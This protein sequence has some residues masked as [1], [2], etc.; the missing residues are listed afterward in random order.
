[1]LNKSIGFQVLF[2]FFSLFFLAPYLYG[3]LNDWS[4][5]QD[6]RRPLEIEF[7]ML[8]QLIIWLFIFFLFFLFEKIKIFNLFYLPFIHIIYEKFFSR[9]LAIVF[10]YCSI[11]FYLNFDFSFRQSADGVLE[12]G[13][14]VM[15]LVPLKIYFSLLPLIQQYENIS[16]IDRLFMLIIFLSFCMT[17]TTSYE[18]VYVFIFFGLFL[19]EKGFLIK[20]DG[21][22]NFFP[23]FILIILPILIIFF[24][25]NNK[26]YASLAY[27]SDLSQNI[28]FISESLSSRLSVFSYSSIY[29]LS[30]IGELYET[31][32]EAISG[33]INIGIYRFSLLL[34]YDLT[35]TEVQNLN[36]LN[37]QNLFFDRREDNGASPGFLANLILFPIFPLGFFILLFVFFILLRSFS[38]FFIKE[39]FSPVAVLFFLPLFQSLT[40]NVFSILS[41]I[42]E[43]F[44]ILLCYI[45]AYSR[46]KRLNA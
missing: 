31:S 18:I 16:F 3:L 20:K 26:S 39:N 42:D 44:I 4:N 34:G 17:L 23:L 35:A 2:L 45:A 10:F 36:I 7:L 46:V 8:I 9:F 38:V 6:F 28:I 33:S 21:S 19:S 24:G 29:Y 14:L 5:F 32:F 40:S 25:I 30:S 22:K 15:L 12:A 1:M 37:S 43:T 11:Y 41:I 27:S 13:F